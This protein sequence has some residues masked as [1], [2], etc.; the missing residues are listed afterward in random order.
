MRLPALL[1]HHDNEVD[2]I[3]KG[4]KDRG[5]PEARARAKGKET[6]IEDVLSPKEIRAAP[7]SNNVATNPNHR[8]KVPTNQEMVEEREETVEKAEAANADQ[9][10]TEWCMHHALPSTSQ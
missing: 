5:D 10:S 9:C 7:T 3:R 1:A 2:P 4:R 6:K 8:E